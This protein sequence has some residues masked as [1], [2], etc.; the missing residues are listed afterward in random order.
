M[1]ALP[2]PRPRRAGATYS[3]SSSATDPAYQTL[4]RSVTRAT[5]IAGEPARM[6]IVCSVASRMRNRSARIPGPGV[7]VSNSRL[8]SSSSRATTSASSTVARRTGQFPVSTVAPYDDLIAA[9]LRESAEYSAC[10]DDGASALRV[11]G[12]RRRRVRPERPEDRVM[13]DAGQFGAAAPGSITDDEPVE[14]LVPVVLAFV[15]LDEA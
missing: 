5:P 11:G 4:G 12:D 9:F 10:Q 2:M 7:G 13:T 8:K 15:D 3:S 6:A 14:H 1:M